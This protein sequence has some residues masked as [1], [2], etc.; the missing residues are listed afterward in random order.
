MMAIFIT[1]VWGFDAPVSPLQF[2]S[3]GWRNNALK[4]LSPGDLVVLVGTHGDE[5]PEAIRGRLVGIMEP[6]KELVKSLDFAVRQR[7]TDFVD[8]E[9][10]WP[11]GLLN[12]KAWSLP[13]RPLLSDISDRKFSMDSAQGIVPLTDGEAARVLALRRVEEK[14]LEPTANTQKVLEKKYGAAKRTAPPPTTTRTGVMHMRSAPAYTYAMQVQQANIQAFKIGWAFD[15]KLRAHQFNHAA[16]PELGGL[17][18]VPTLTHLW[19]T[20]RLAYRMEQRLLLQFYDRRH[21][22][23]NEIIVRVS[24]R[25][26]DIAWQAGVGKQL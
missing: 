14:L 16:M 11:Y 19:D 4:Q 3:P 21:E 9:Y 7:P 5:T 23:N 17:H 25:E 22:K 15:V 12:L 18:Y 1:K 26:L 13:E 6:T 24:P 10:K 20:A 8:G 2:S